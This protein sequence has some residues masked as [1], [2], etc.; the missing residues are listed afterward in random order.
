MEKAKRIGID[1]YRDEQRAK[2][3]ILHQ[4]LD[5]FDDGRHDV[6]FCLAANMLA[7]EDLAAAVEKASEQTEDLSAT[8]KRR[9][10][11]TAE[12][13]LRETATEKDVPLELR[14]WNGPWQ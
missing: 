7:L 3:A 14:T 5:E 11:E 13:I 9:R 6:F 8:Q 4:L 10:A 1:A 12:R 2:A